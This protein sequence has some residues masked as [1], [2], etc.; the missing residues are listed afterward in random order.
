[1]RT[2]PFRVLLP[3]GSTTLP[4]SSEKDPSSYYGR[5]PGASRQ[6]S[7]QP[8]AHVLAEQNRGDVGLYPRFL[9]C[10]VVACISHQFSATVPVHGG[11]WKG[12]DSG[13]GR[14]LDPHEFSLSE[15][16]HLA[17]CRSQNPYPST[18]H[19]VHRSSRGALNTMDNLHCP[20]HLRFPLTQA[21]DKCGVGGI[22]HRF[23]L[24]GRSISCIS[25]AFLAA[26]PAWQ[27]LKNTY[28][29][30]TS[31]SMS[32]IFRAHSLSSFSL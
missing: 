15:A 1:M 7:R 11:G 2:P 17:S 28:T 3:Y 13:Y 19:R 27:L 32:R 21:G 30:L 10:Q 25:C 12:K 31:F 5:Q 14:V 24:S 8:G 29:F 18:R 4:G 6:L 23:S 9:I 20:D 16:C 22:S 26:W